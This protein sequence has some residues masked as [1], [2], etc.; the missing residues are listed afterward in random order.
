MDTQR[1]RCEF[2]EETKYSGQW[3][4]LE[5]RANSGMTGALLTGQKMMRKEHILPEFLD[6]LTDP[7]GTKSD[8][9]ESIHV[10]VQS[11]KDVVSME[12]LTTQFVSKFTLPP[13]D[14]INNS[15]YLVSISSIA[16]PLCVFKNY[17]GQHTQFF[18]A[19]PKRRWGRCFG[20]RI[21]IINNKG[22]GCQSSGGDLESNSGVDVLNY[23][24]SSDNDDDNDDDNDE[25][26]EDDD[27]DNDDDNEE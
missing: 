11:S 7:M 22:P 16:H 9:M 14:Q 19:L 12:T 18:C 3:H 4:P 17:S 21:Q 25:D 23:G 27:D 20:D 2:K 10:V 15:T 5:T 24:R 6:L 13:K 8:Y 1:V 26:D